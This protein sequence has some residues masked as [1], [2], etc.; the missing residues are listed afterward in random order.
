MKATGED[1]VPT[2]VDARAKVGR[3]DAC[4]C[5]SGRKFKKCCGAAP[6]EATPIAK[7]P[8]LDVAGLMNLLRAAR[9]AELESTARQQLAEQAHSGLLWK[10]LG[11]ALHAQH[12]D[13]LPA[14]EQAAQLLPDDAEAQTNL[15]NVLRAR[16]R[17]QEAQECQHRAIRIKPDYAEAHN[18]LGSVLKDLGELDSAVASYRRAIVLKPQFALAHHN[19]G[20]TLRELGRLEDALGAYRR[21]IALVPDFADAHAHLG[22]A[23]LDLGRRDEAVASFRRALML[24]P[25]HAA[26]LR[27]MGDTLLQLEKPQAAAEHYRRL[28]A[29]RSDEPEVLGN[30][31][32]ALRALG[33]FAQARAAYQ[34]ALEL[35]PDLADA[36]NHLGNA[37]LDLG[38]FADAEACYRRALER[39]AGSAHFHAN[40][41]TALRELARLEEAEASLLRA[42]E[43][44]PSSAEVL[45]TL[46]S[47]RRLLARS[48]EAEVGLKRALELDPGSVAARIACADLAADRGDFDGAEAL[49]RQSFAQDPRS[50]SAWA[51]IV[52]TRRMTREDAP[53]LASA[54]ALLASTLR[55][56]DE[57]ALRFAMGKYFDDL[58]EYDAAFAAYSSANER[59]KTYCP[60]HDRAQV[61]TRFAA[62][63]ERWTAESVAALRSQASTRHTPIFVVG[64]P[65]SGT[66]LA[67]Q[68][69]ASHPQVHG[70]GEQ[71]FWGEVAARVGARLLAAGPDPEPLAAAASDY[72]RLLGQLTPGPLHVVDKMPFNFAHLGLIHAALPRARIIHMRRNPIDTCLSIYFQNFHVVQSYATDL[73]DL[74]HYYG[75]YG[76][77]MQHWLHVL[78]AGTVLEVP[79][80]ALV[81]APDVWSRRMVEFAGLPWNDACL[82]AHE[83]RRAVRTFSRWQ[84]RQRINT[85]SVER[86]R[87][88]AAHVGPL[89]TLDPAAGAR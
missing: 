28:L 34:R 3:N 32:H 89:L 45:I 69:L 55:P 47:V 81:Q 18:N 61:E 49:Y 26:A 80:E 50:A 2:K 79:Y 5:G 20:L 21:A 39:D 42:A 8:A 66:S 85:G 24:Q 25:E 78:P 70:A 75:E 13:P 17:L 73:A 1:E 30:L 44:D 38:Q 56:R 77:L 52:A 46:A 9:Y 43:L 57:A 51:G 68:I 16:G 71:P 27:F 86:W 82:T 7:A 11:A 12:K 37:L 54:E 72:D 64:M 22:R 40:L 53:W 33:D 84:V 48:D 83:T 76:R 87:R 14:L 4:R 10:L 41:G 63:R 23:L 29:L 36:H 31:G 19:L 62:V 67:E 58:Q 74:A 60:P 6:T 88:Y 15:G 59:V 35:R 65:R